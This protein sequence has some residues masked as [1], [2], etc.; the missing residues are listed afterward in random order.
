VQALVSLCSDDTARPTHSAAK[1]R[2]ILCLL[3]EG[4]EGSQRLRKAQVAPAA[5]AWDRE[6][7]GGV[8]MLQRQLGGGS[9]GCS[10]VYWGPVWYSLCQNSFTSAAKVG[11]AKKK[12]RARL[13]SSSF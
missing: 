13:A 11:E 1:S 6:G 3:R 2:G 10:D 5:G 9:R 8:G 12:K 7:V 4:M